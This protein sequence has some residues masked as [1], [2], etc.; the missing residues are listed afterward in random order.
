MCVILTNI[1]HIGACG[2]DL[3]LELGECADE[4][5]RTLV[6]CALAWAIRA[7][8]PHQAREESF[9]KTDACEREMGKVMGQAMHEAL[10]LFV[11]EAGEVDMCEYERAPFDRLVEAFAVR[12]EDPCPPTRL[13]QEESDIADQEAQ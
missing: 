8:M 7:Q 10:R 5:T 2:P 12:R 13:E 1:V 4:R 3:P 11:H 6:R 9:E